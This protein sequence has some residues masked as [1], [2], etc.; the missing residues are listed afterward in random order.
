MNDSS[1]DVYWYFMGTSFKRNNATTIHEYCS[2]STPPFA[3]IKDYL[4][5]TFNNKPDFRLFLNQFVHD[6]FAFNDNIPFGFRDMAVSKAQLGLQ[7]KDQGKNFDFIY[8]GE[9]TNRRIDSIL[10]LFSRGR[11]SQRNILILSKKYEQLQS[12]YRESSNILFRGPVKRDEVDDYLL[13]SRFGLNL[14]PNQYPYNQQTSTKFLEYAAAKLPIISTDYE[15]VRKFQEQYGGQYYFMK[16]DLSNLKWEDINSF[17][18]S[19]P[20]LDNWTWEHRIRHS[21]VLEF[22]ESKFPSLNLTTSGAFG[23]I[24]R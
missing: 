23:R 6:S 17:S 7:N 20:E 15:W 13:Q 11:L 16:D 12:N 21:G 10:E 18:Y 2:A 19:W 22:L 5:R 3:H 24:L 8:I 9:L 1:A 14:I 4:K